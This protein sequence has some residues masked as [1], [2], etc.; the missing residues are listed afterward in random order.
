MIKLTFKVSSI[1]EAEK[2]EASVESAL[3]KE[4]GRKALRA[5]RRGRILS[6]LAQKLG[7]MLVGV[8]V[9]VVFIITLSLMMAGG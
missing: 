7:W 1:E 9:F 5:A 6:E 3:G 8:A 2:V 4:E